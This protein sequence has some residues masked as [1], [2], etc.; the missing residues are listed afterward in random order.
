[1]Q[2]RT[3]EFFEDAYLIAFA[4]VVLMLAI[5]IIQLVRIL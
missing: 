5:S 4:L 1:M 3:R 2:R